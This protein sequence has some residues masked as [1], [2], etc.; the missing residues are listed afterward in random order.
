MSHYFTEK[1][2]VKSEIFEYETVV[3]N[4]K[5]SF[6]S[7]NGVFSKEHL[8]FGSRLLIE[9]FINPKTKGILLDLGCGIGVIGLSLAKRYN[10]NLMMADINERA[11]SLAEQNMNKNGIFGAV[12]QANILEGIDAKFAVVVTNPPIRAGKQIVFSFFE[13]S[14]DHLIE[15]GE[16]WVV[17]RKQQG[18]DSAI[19]KIQ[20]IF[21]NCVIVKKKGGFCILKAIKLS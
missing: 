2:S 20:E 3:L 1:Q 8:D 14:Y 7:D 13:Q 17:I 5:I 6:F 4:Q 19:K 18:A 16:L 15:N 10:R 9:E 11:V 21:K 12:R